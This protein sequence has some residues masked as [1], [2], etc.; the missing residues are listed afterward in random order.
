MIR[1][2]PRSTLF[3][4][5]TLFRSQLVHEAVADVRESVVDLLRR[6]DSSAA[7]ILETLRSER[8][9]LATDVRGER[10]AVVL[11]ADAE[12]ASLARDAARIADQV[13]KASGE[14]ARRLAR[15]V[16]LLL[17]VLAIVLLGLPFA[18]GN[19]VGRARTGRTPADGG[20]AVD[21]KSTR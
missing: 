3:P 4:Y 9:A 17:G 11:A 8:A 6:V 5:T 7:S 20:K 18:A 13:V 14:Q 15:E 21:R 16:L 19:L 10:E 2:P 1:R 12:R